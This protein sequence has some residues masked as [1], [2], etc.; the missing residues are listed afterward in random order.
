M[1]DRDRNQLSVRR[2]CQ[3][4]KVNR[5]RLDPAKHHCSS[6][7][8]EICRQI[9]EIHLKAPAFGSRNIR[10]ILEVDCG[11]RISRGRVRRLMRQMGIRAIYQRPRTS[12]PGQGEEHKVFA[13]LLRE[14]QV[15]RPDE[16][17]CTDI[18]YLPI[19]R[20]FAYL[21]A[22]MDWHSRAVLSWKLSNTMD[23]RFCLEALDEAVQRA[24]KVPEIFNTDQGRQF[25][26][27]P[28]RRR[29]EELGVQISMD[30]KGR[31]M[32]NV[33]IERLCPRN[34]PPTNLGLPRRA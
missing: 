34:D 17:R 18:T 28:W 2:Q 21:V 29:L 19:G 16:V 22:V 13:Y 11:R 24:G 1:I 20:S 8:L 23:T 9:D 33:F 4:L 32:D 7:E 30:G 10:R 25:T 12:L 26:S 3:L 27:R 14:R 31:W 5:N 15:K 6:Q